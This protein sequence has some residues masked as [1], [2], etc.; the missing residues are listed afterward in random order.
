MNRES[1]LFLSPDIGEESEMDRL[2]SVM[3]RLASS[4]FLLLTLLKT[5]KVWG[6]SQMELELEEETSAIMTGCLA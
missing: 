1:G 6:D 3:C 2:D 4:S 5:L